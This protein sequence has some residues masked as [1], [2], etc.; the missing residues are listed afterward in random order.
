MH[1]LTD[2]LVDELS[3]VASETMPASAVAHTKGRLLDYLG[4]SLAGSRM[5]RDKGNSLLDALGN[6]SG[7]CTVIGFQRR[8]SMLQAALLNGLSSHVAELD[9]GER[10]AMLHPG[11]PVISALLAVAEARGLTG[12]ELILGMVVGYEATVRTGRAMQP[13]IKEAGYHATGICGTLGTA[14]GVAAAL[15]Y[16]REQLKSALSAAATGA[17]GI[18]EVIDDGSLLKPYNAAHAALEGLTAA[19]VGGAGFTGPLDALGGKRG[20]IATLTD[21][22]DPA[23]LERQSGEC[24][25]IENAYVKPYAACRHCHPAVDTAL[26]IIRDEAFDPRNVQAVEVKTYHWAVG[27]HDHSDIQGVSSAKMSTPYSVAVALLYGKAGLNE[28]MPEKLADPAV[29]ALT[30]KVRVIADAELTSLFP[31]QRAA[32]TEIVLNNGQRFANRVDLPKGE[33]E[34]PLSEAELRAKFTE[35]AMY[36]GK[37][38]REAE[39]IQTLVDE[40]ETGLEDLYSNL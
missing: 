8:T 3:Q 10:F 35:L 40:I 15:G 5:I 4:V 30:H 27:G 17:A 31:A 33:P 1:N 36:G 20:L 37:T 18:L 29:Q 38:A 39:R 11:A 13:A 32:S 25:R 12:R 28:F 14:V 7:P 22:F 16:S 21:R 19:L 34:Y 6:T 26:N 24:L 9:D 23:K 2:F